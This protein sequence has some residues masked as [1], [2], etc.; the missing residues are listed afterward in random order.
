VPAL[1]VQQE[2]RALMAHKEL[3]VL[4]ERLAVRELTELKALLVHKELLV[5]KER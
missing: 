3:L 4:K 5:L 2:A 1:K